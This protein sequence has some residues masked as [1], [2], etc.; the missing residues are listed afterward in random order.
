MSEKETIFTKGIFFNEK[1]DKAPDFVLGGVSIKPKEFGEFL[2]EN[3]EHIK[4]GTVK[5]SILRSKKTDKPYLIIDTYVPTQRDKDA[6]N[7]QTNSV[8]HDDGTNDPVPFD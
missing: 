7:E 2:R 5:L 4:D 8:V 1:H 6:V 3:K